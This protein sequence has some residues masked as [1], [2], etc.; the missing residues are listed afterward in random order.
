M[1]FFSYVH[2]TIRS[3]EFDDIYFSPDDGLAETAHV[4]LRGN[5][6]PAAWEK[7]QRFT[8]TETGFGTGLNF[9]SVWKMFEE[10]ALADAALDFIS[11]EKYPLSREQI[12]S[13]LSPWAGFFSGRLARLV[14]TYPLRVNGFHRVHVTDRVHLTLIFDDVNDA[15]PQLMAPQGVNAWFLD[16]FAPAKNPQMWSDTIFREMARLSAPGA[17]VASFTAAGAVR[18]G[19]AAQGFDV[20]K[21]RGYGRKRDMTTAVYATYKSI[22]AQKIPS[23][24]AIIGAGLAG[25]ACAHALKRRGLDVVIFDPHGIAQFASGNPRGIYNPRFS[26]FRTPESDFY[27]SGYALMAAQNKRE[28]RCGSLH[29]VTD[30]DKRKRFTGVLN[31]WGWHTDHAQFLDAGR[32]SEKAGI[33]LTQDALWLPDSGYA[34]PA[35][36]CR[37]YAGDVSIQSGEYD[38]RDFGAVILA[39]GISAKEYPGLDN[40]PLHTVRGQ[41][42]LL[43]SPRAPLIKSNICYGGYLS[44]HNDGGYVAGAT[45]QQWRTDVDVTDEDH[46][47]ILGLLYKNVP[48]LTDC[49]KVQGGRSSLRCAAKDR[50]PVIGRVPDSL[51]TYVSTAHGSHGLISTAAGA[52]Y[53]TDLICGGPVSLSASSA[54][55]L[56]PVRFRNRRAKKDGQ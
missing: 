12:E 14:E 21:V 26:Q 53:L 24:V 7:S 45:F 13:A 32:A 2:M 56:D 44:A 33:Q 5:N 48:V 52:E 15:L 9:L 23:R 6:L 19:L 18:R 54:A 50:F 39:N 31:N 16:G 25:T 51:H 37:N 43:E 17:T 35:A 30:N 10:T 49:F 28:Q 3:T 20:T 36:L 38:P 8:I 11:F 22:P 47:E 1:L 27:S 40:L 34:H 41:I 46:Q 4:F 29:L 42:S 55:A